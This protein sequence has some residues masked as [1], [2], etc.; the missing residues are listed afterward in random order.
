MTAA[1]LNTKHLF[2]IT[3]VILCNLFRSDNM[4]N[5]SILISPFCLSYLPYVCSC[6]C[7]QKWI[8]QQ[9]INIFSPYLV[10]RYNSRL[11]PADIEFGHLALKLAKCRHGNCWVNGEVVRYWM[12]MQVTFLY[13][14]YLF[15]NFQTVC[16]NKLFTFNYRTLSNYSDYRET[17]RHMYTLIINWKM[18]HK[19]EYKLSSHYK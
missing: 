2:L 15:F 11:V 16:K 12:V 9:W 17:H 3:L 18:N 6:V 13:I 5:W 4:T 19:L 14:T 7:V 8:S 1:D 10:D